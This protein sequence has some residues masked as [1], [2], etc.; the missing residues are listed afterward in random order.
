VK[1]VDEILNAAD[2]VVE[3]ISTEDIASTLY[4]VVD[5]EDESEVSAREEAE[6]NRRM[7]SQALLRKLR[8]VKRTL[9]AMKGNTIL[10]RSRRLCL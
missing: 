3:K 6:K 8:I 4:P 7:L 10:G 1:Q 2:A 9:D 5:S